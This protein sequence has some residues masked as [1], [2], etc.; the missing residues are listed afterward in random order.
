MATQLVTAT[1]PALTSVRRSL[2]LVW[3]NP[4]SRRF[5]RMGRI[6]LLAHGR[7][8]FRYA[9][10]SVSDPEFVPLV[11][12]PDVAA[13]YLS[14]E[15]PAFFANRVMSPDR[16]S[17]ERYLAWLGV[18]QL[19]SVDLPLEMLARTGGGKATDTFHL[20]DLPLEA[21][22][23][24]NSR[25]FVSGVRH[26]TDIDATL[27][28]LHAGDP[29][30]LKPDPENPGNSRAVLVSAV[31]GEH[32]GYVPDWLCDDVT[33][34]LGEGWNVSASVERVNPDAPDHVKLLCRIEASR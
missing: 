13:V 19:E 5:L 10:E 11:D 1:D 29:L 8:A 20:M 23:T 32:V 26:R 24:F 17:Y 33:R 22:H 2:L 4:Q 21:D 28:R 14:D 16:P 30:V 31:T 25:F 18:D 34:L 6:D 15:L 9:Q 3:Q 7:F 12:Y 27:E